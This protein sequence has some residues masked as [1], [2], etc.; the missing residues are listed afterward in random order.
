MMTPVAVPAAADKNTYVPSLAVPAVTAVV[1]SIAL[2]VPAARVTVP[3]LPLLIAKLNDMFMLKI[4]A[5][6]STRA[7]YNEVADGNVSVNVVPVVVMYPPM[8]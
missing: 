2:S 3:E 7:V 4:A 5:V 8:S 6:L 1:P